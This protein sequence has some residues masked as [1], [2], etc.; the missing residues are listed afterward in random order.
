MKTE[1]IVLKVIA[2]LKDRD[3]DIVVDFAKHNLDNPDKLVKYF[4]SY[5]KRN[6]INK[7]DKVIILN[8]LKSKGVDLK[9]HPWRKII[10][11]FGVV[12]TP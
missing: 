1:T 5:S 9:K 10:T 6:N 4:E 2:R 12:Y 3:L 11:D 7:A 8:K